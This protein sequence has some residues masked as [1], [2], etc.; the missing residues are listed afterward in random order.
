M[1]CVDKL[2]PICGRENSESPKC[3]A[4]SYRIVKLPNNLKICSR[5]YTNQWKM[6]TTVSDTVT[7][8]SRFYAIFTSSWKL[9]AVQFQQQNSFRGPRDKPGSCWQRIIRREE[10][11]SPGYFLSDSV[12]V[13]VE[14]N[15]CYSPIFSSP[16]FHQN[17]D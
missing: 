9:R 13:Q 3:T 7:G 14:R 2:P 1:F 15:W 4:S 11:E 12:K 8:I 6:K 16:N 5:N 10:F 17:R